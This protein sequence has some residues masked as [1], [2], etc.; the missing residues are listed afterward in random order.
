MDYQK[1]LKDSP[2]GFLILDKPSG[3]TSHDCI[4]KIRKIIGIKKIGHAGTLDPAVTGVLPVAI[5]NATRLIP[6]LKGSKTYVGSIQLGQVTSTDDISGEIISSAKVPALTS[7][8][9]DNIL[10]N[11]RGHIQQIPPQV[12]SININGERA[13]ERHRKGEKSIMPSRN[14]EIYELKLINWESKYGLLKI[15]V[16]C[17]SGTYIRSIARDIGELIGCGGCLA[18]L[19]RTQALGFHE[20]QSIKLPVDNNKF[21]INSDSIIN[22]ADALKH[23]PS[24]KLVSEEEIYFWR[25]GRELVLSLDRLEHTK[26][27]ENQ[28]QKTPVAV[29]LDHLLI[30]IGEWNLP[31]NL[32]PKVVFNPKY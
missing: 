9:L 11:F 22:P 3:L 2:F 18:K 1:Q 27:P 6:Y 7:I 24:I 21:A 26:S 13:Y 20:E 16:D 32:K 14:I 25:C 12:S 15:K 19:R 4:N 5:G 17:S 28:L 10:N 23:L 29:K 31:F 8:E 30:G